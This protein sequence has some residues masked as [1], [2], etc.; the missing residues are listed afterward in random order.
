VI[1][2]ANP[3]AQ[4]L[5]YKSGIDSAIRR[6]LESGTYVLGEE[7]ATFED[8]FANWQGSKYCIGVGNGTDALVLA[9]K[10]LGIEPGDEVVTVS[11]TAVATVAAIQVVGATPVL[12][13]ISPSSFTMDPESLNKYVTSKTRAVIPV[14]LYGHP[15]NMPE[16]MKV[17]HR[18]GL[19]V[20]ED[21][22]QAHG[23]KIAGHKVGTFGKTA[24]FSFYPTKNL[25]ALGDGGAVTTNDSVLAERMK[26][27]RQYGWKNKF[28]SEIAGWNSRL[29]E[30]Q[31]AVLRVR[32]AG[33]DRDNCRRRLIANLYNSALAGLGLI[34]PE[35]R[36]DIE[37]VYHLF[38]L[39]VKERDNMLIKLRDMGVGAA[40]HYPQAVHQQPAYTWMNACLPETDRAA[41]EVMT[42]PLYPEMSDQEVEFVATSLRGI[43]LSEII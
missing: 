1:P 14:H 16:I 28:I 41:M 20:I 23:A 4:Y 7:V 11:H 24:T 22:A 10:G 38:V 32:L 5:A 40:V 34:L 25:G 21:C 12:V 43:V 36:Q 31:A 30:L 37:H 9:L 17:A 2:Y 42:L 15:A 27:L 35:S 39:R 13:D 33:L 3:K 26:K 18:H 19:N 6:V 29:D 8:E